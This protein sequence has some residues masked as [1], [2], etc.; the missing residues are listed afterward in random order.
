MQAEQHADVGRNAL[1]A[2]KTQPDREQ[3]AEEGAE[4]GDVGQVVGIE[5]QV[6]LGDLVDE[7]HG[8]RALE[9]IEQQRGGGEALAAGAQHVGGADVAGADV[10]HIAETGGA[11]QQQPEGNGAQK[12]AGKQRQRRI[13]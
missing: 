9:G 4:A 12:V 10:A 2:E 7:Q 13:G 11:R 6:V 3:V 5:D 1:A 8:G